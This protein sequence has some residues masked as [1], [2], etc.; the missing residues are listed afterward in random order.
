M[1]EFD[2]K[3]YLAARKQ[4]IDAAL[5]KS[6]PVAAGLQ[7]KVVEAA[8]YSLFAGAN[9]FVRFFAWLPRRCAEDRLS[10]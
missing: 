10:R 8:R 7:K 1:R 4:L 6:F 5:E 3:S 2:L 9:A